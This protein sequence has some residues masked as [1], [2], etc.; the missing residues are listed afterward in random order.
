MTIDP[1]SEYARLCD[2]FDELGA[3]DLFG[4]YKA[5][6]HHVGHVSDAL[7]DAGALIYVGKSA[8]AHRARFWLAFIEAQHAL[9]RSRA[10]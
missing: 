9:R 2:V 5:F 4:T 8:F 1:P 7:V 10:K 6:E 3:V